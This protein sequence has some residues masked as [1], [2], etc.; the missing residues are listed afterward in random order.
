[1]A[2][3]EREQNKVLRFTSGTTSPTNDSGKKYQATAKY[4]RKLL[5]VRLSIEEWMHYQLQKLYSCQV[6]SINSI[7]GNS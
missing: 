7:Y 2:E 5:K 1:M 3:D 6:Y 4:D